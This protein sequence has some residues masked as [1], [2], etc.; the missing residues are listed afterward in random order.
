MPKFNA[1]KGLYDD[2]K[3]ERWELE[4]IAKDRTKIIVQMWNRY[5][6]IHSFLEKNA[7]NLLTGA[8]VIKIMQKA[9]NE[10]PIIG[11]GV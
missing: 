4:Y 11:V 10:F 8:D 1:E 3:M 6:R 9:E 2:S 5:E 7:E